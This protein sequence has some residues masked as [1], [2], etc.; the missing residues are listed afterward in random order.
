[1]PAN[2]AGMFLPRGMG[3]PAPKVSPPGVGVAEDDDNF[4]EGADNLAEGSN[5]EDEGDDDDDEK[6]EEEEERRW[7]RRQRRRKQRE[8]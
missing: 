2:I 6:E 4:D 8:K 5:D 7:R 1:M 3:G